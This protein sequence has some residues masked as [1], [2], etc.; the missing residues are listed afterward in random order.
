[1]QTFSELALSLYKLYTRD[2]IYR[3]QLP[4]IQ[5]SSTISLTRLLLEN[6]ARFT[7]TKPPENEA[8]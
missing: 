7:P 6:H 4:L 2:C 5:L 1:M 8:I 3:L